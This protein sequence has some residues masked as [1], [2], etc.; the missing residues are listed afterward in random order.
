MSE[1]V[2]PLIPTRPVSQWPVGI[3]LNFRDDADLHEH[4]QHLRSKPLLV[5]SGLKLIG[6]GEGPYSWRQQVLALT[7]GTFGWA[8]PDQLGLPIDGD[9][10]D[11]Y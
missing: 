1:P 2:A 3:R 7:T 4:Y 8:R 11:V 5:L 9:V 10:P 6:N